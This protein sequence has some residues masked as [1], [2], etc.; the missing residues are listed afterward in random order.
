MR[1][2]LIAMPRTSNTPIYDFP[3]A[4][5]SQLVSANTINSIDLI[6][7]FKQCY[8]LIIYAYGSPLTFFYIAESTNKMIVFFNLF[9]FTS[10]LTNRFYSC[11]KVNRYDRHKA[12]DQNRPINRVGVVLQNTPPYVGI[13]K[14]LALGF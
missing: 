2:V 14:L 13:S 7:M 11:N 1:K 3:F 9:L 4:Q 10:Q 12:N 8:V 6:L 5:G